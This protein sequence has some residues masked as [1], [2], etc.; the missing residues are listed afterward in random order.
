[1]LLEFLHLPG[2]LEVLVDVPPV[3]C[4][5]LV[6]K[7]HTGPEDLGDPVELGLPE[8]GELDAGVFDLLDDGEKL[9]DVE[10]KLLGACPAK[11]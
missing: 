8:L 4:K 6:G 9:L 5:D 3:R 11:G 2:Q 10:N 7:L 1:M